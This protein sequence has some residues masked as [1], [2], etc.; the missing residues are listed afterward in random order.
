M[1][2]HFWVL[3]F[4]WTWSVNQALLNKYKYTVA[5][6]AQLINKRRQ[7]SP[8]IEKG[9]VS[10]PFKQR[11]CLTSSL[12]WPGNLPVCRSR[13]SPD[14][15]FVFVEK[16]LIHWSRS[17]KFWH[18]KVWHHS[19]PSSLK[20]PYFACVVSHSCSLCILDLLINRWK[21]C[22]LLCLFACPV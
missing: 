21:V 9:A 7:Q 18:P 22:L 5:L 20:Y 6:F 3:K 11:R 16:D 19:V 15:V 4:I 2:S 14:S 13:T 8:T 10:F 12:K 1:V 17:Y